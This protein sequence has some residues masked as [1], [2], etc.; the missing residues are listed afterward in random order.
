MI[1]HIS[2]LAFVVVAVVLGA[3]GAQPTGPAASGTLLRDMAGP[4]CVDTVYE[5]ARASTPA[6]DTGG[7]PATANSSSSGCHVVIIYY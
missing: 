5:P 2:V 1:R 3:C 4:E 7:G 6:M